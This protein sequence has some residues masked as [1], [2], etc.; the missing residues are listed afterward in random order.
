VLRGAAC[1]PVCVRRF[2]RCATT[3]L[4]GVDEPGACRSGRAAVWGLNSVANPSCMA[5]LGSRHDIADGSFR[6]CGW[7]ASRLPGR[8]SLATDK[9]RRF[10]SMHEIAIDMGRRYRGSMMVRE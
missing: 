8:K 1:A 7:L 9:K 2:G 10:S 4:E 5:R 6:G 3:C